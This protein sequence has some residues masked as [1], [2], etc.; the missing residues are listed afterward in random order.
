MFKK[1]RAWLDS[2][3][4]VA[5]GTQHVGWLL[6]SVIMINVVSFVSGYFWGKRTGAQEWCTVTSRDAFADQI[7][8]S[9]CLAS[10][11][12][13]DD[14]ESQESADNAEAS[15]T[16]VAQ[17]GE[18]EEAPEK[19][20]EMKTQYYAQLAGFS[21]LRGAEAFVARLNKNRFLYLSKREPA[22]VQK[23]DSFV[24]TRL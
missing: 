13:D 3:K 21:S 11:G 1:I 14:S 15:D 17:A 5:M 19:G 22:K 6:A 20:L 7:Y 9:L 16:D 8:N 24:G 4:P 23:G 2:D 10:V 12:E 18:G